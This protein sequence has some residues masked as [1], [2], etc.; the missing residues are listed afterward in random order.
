M[1]VLHVHAGNLFGGIETL[2]VTLAKE[3]SLC[4]QM[5]PHFALCFEGR[6]ANELESLNANVHILGK[7]KISL[8]WT[9]WKARQQLQQLLNQERFNVVICH[10][11]WPQ[12][13][14]GSVV[15]AK[16]LPLVFWCHDV[17]NGEHPLE[18]LAKLIAPDLVIA[19]SRYT[20]ASVPKLYPTH[21]DTLYLPVTAA[22]MG[23]NTAIRPAVRDEL[24]TPEDA[25]VIVQAS[26]L[27][28]WKGQ[29]M[30]IH[31]LGQLRNI[32]NWICWIAGG[33]QRPYE[34]EYL[35]EL[36]EQT[37]KLGIADRVLFLGQRTDVQRLLAAA[38]IHC[39]PNT[40]AE[41]F[42]IA[43][44]EAL[45]AG[46][47]VVTTAIGGAMEIVDDTCG[48]LVAANDI[49]AL[50]QV[51]GRLISHPDERAS[52]ASGGKARAE[53]FC[54]PHKQINRLYSLL[55]QVVEQKAVA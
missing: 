5:Q 51:L 18:R 52:L 23:D 30:L 4:P 35:A 28:R 44:I 11:C 50:S 10:S 41:P 13:I 27:E 14:F 15:R 38:D 46:L 9:V 1:K 37:Q 54:N 19:N 21:S 29:S 26:R 16:N 33:V 31:A 34:A 36:K 48:R 45:Y 40:G 2:L 25:V 43:F 53:Y 8:P 7:V 55:F 49:D 6:L 3:Q 39:Q 22:N 12:T 42:G 24:N 32:P 47:P 20:Q 17:P